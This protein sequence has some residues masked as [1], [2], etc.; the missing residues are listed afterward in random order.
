MDGIV[1]FQCDPRVCLFE[2]VCN[3]SDFF[4]DVYKE[5]HLCVVLFVCLLDVVVGCLWVGVLCVWV[6][7]PLFS[8]MACV[9][10]L[11]SLTLL[12]VGG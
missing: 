12:S 2:Q 6:G 1:C 9:V 10:L 5:T 3:E 8:I 7:K 4:T 11:S